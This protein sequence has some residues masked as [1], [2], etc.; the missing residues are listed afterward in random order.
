ML[1]QI[2]LDSLPWL[3]ISGIGRPRFPQLDL[4]LVR[5]FLH[6][7]HGGLRVDDL[8]P[9]L[10][11]LFHGKPSLSSERPGPPGSAHSTVSTPGGRALRPPQALLGK[12]AYGLRAGCAQAP[13]DLLHLGL[14]LSATAAGP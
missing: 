4:D 10:R 7:Q 5:L 11:D 2:L 13:V 14:E 3:E 9:I 12:N 1:A 8:D 6:V